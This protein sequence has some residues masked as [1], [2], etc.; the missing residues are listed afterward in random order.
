MKRATAIWAGVALA[1]VATAVTHADPMPAD[2]Q[3]VLTLLGKTGD[4]QDNALKINIP[5]DDLQ[6]SINK[7]AVPTPFGF[8]G[9]MAMTKGQSGEEVMMGDLVLTEGEVGPVMSAL[10][11]NGIQVTGL[12][13]HFFFE[14]PRVFFLHV[15]GMGPA[16]DL[17][18]RLKPATD[19]IDSFRA[20]HL[21]GAAAKPT[22]AA[23]PG[24]D[25]AQVDQIIGHKGQDID[26]VHKITIGRDD[27]DLTEMGA[28]I[29]TR[30]GLNIWAAFYGT[31]QQAMVA[32]DIAMLEGEVNP[33]LIALRKH[34]LDV[35]AVHQH[36]LGSPTPII[37][38]HYWGQGPAAQLAQG[39]KAALDH[40]GPMPAGMAQ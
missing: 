32:G 5:R 8:G 2:Y 37:F 31:D 34:D 4:F 16:T 40:L 6:V 9:W 15:H 11:D 35:V 21:K 38:L 23:K 19:M 14:S 12:H 20:G 28:K 36:M 24:L 29:G 22:P 3:A 18:T 1:A 26:A 33:V 39:F 10:L 13:N 17:A 7:V 27:L 30:M 25:T